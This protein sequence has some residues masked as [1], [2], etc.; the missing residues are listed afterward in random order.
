[1]KVVVTGASGLIGTVLV[2]HLR[3]EGHDVLTLVRRAPRTPSEVHW[4]P[5]RGTITQ[6]ALAGTDAAVHYR[7]SR[8]AR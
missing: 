2:A 6:A 5:A 3:R 4:D 1:M 8:C 7:C